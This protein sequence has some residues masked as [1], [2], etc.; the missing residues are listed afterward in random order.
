MFRANDIVMLRRKHLFWVQIGGNTLNATVSGDDQ[1]S[2]EVVR[3][4]ILNI[5]NARLRDSR[6]FI[7]QVE[8]EL[9][10]ADSA[11]AALEKSCERCI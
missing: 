2:E 10:P 5:Q 8:N 7:L 11:F 9:P 4:K 6:V 1:R 3:A